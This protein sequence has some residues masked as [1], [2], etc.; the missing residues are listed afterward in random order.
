MGADIHVCVEQMVDGV[1][2]ER[3]ESP[4][5]NRWYGFSDSDEEP[6]FVYDDWFSSRNYSLF[7]MLADV[8]N[9]YG[10]AGVD[11]GDQVEP[12]SKPRGIPDDASASTKKE[13]DWW[14][15]DGHSHTWFSAGDLV[16]VPWETNTI[17]HR[18]V[19]IGRGEDTT[20]V[21]TRV[22]WETSWAE[23]VGSDWLAF[24]VRLAGLNPQDLSASRAVMWFDN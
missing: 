3:A 8:R 2:W 18:G 23:A 15:C 17:T 1:G 13:V 16:A 9:G 6:E 19:V 14:G 11:I 10:F 7:A 21:Y 20:G 4:V 24:V 22:E 5:P 12:I